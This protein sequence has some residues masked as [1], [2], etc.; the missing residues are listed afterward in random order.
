VRGKEECHGRT[1]MAISS[2]HGSGVEVDQ[3]TSKSAESVDASVHPRNQCLPIQ[4]CCKFAR[5]IYEEQS[6]R[7]AKAYVK[8]VIQ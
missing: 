2:S 6:R 1:K 4:F 3:T 8:K 7:F 5:L